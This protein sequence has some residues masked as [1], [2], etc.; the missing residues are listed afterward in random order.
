MFAGSAFSFIAVSYTTLSIRLVADDS[1]SSIKRF[2]RDLRVRLNIQ[3]NRGMSSHSIL[4]VKVKVKLMSRS[5]P[6][7]TGVSAL[8]LF[9][10]FLTSITPGIRR[11]VKRQ[12]EYAGSWEDVHAASELKRSL[13][14]GTTATGLTRSK[15]W[16]KR[17]TRLGGRGRY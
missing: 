8:L 12:Q 14:V 17:M 11:R 6:I 4:K 7:M 13:S 3:L 16:M 9:L 15:T 5:V 10:S 2:K 1:S